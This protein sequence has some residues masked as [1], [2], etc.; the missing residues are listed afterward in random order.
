[1]PDSKIPLPPA[2]AAPSASQSLRSPGF[3]LAAG[4]FDAHAAGGEGLM[5]GLLV[6]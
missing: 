1:M 2:A 4:D 3:D 5:K 6:F